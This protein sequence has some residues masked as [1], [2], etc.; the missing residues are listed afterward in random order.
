VSLYYTQNGRRNT[1]KYVN[2]PVAKNKWHTLRVEFAG[3][4]IR[5]ALDGKLY[6]EQEA[7]HI[8]GAGSIGV[9]TKADSV[10]VFDDFTYSSAASR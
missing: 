10:T 6:I 4:T 8:S 9:W 1:I 7:D 5:V 3:K 2:A